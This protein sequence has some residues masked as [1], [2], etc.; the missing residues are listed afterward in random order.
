[1]TK[2]GFGAGVIT[3][4]VPVFLAGFSAR[5]EPATGVYDELEARAVVIDDDR[6]RLC[7]V[8]CDLLGMSPGVSRRVRTEVSEAIELPV[9]RVLTACTHT[10]TGPSLLQGT[11][12]LGWPTPPE[13]EATV[14]HGC[15]V[16]ARQAVAALEPGSLFCARRSLPEAVSMNRRQ[17]PYDPTFAVLDAR[18]D[19]GTTIGTLANVGIHPVALGPHCL[20]VSTDWVGPFRA[21]LSAATGGEAALLQ[22]ALGDVNPVEPHHHDEHG[23]YHHAA[24]IGR[25]V[26]EAVRAILAELEP[27]AGPVGAAVS[28]TIAAP[29]GR[30]PITAMTKLKGD[31]DVELV[32]WGLGD[33]RLVSIPGEAFHAFGNEVM[34]S[35]TGEVLL[36][37]LAPSW[38]GYLP[39]PWGDGYEEGVSYGEP[40]VDAVLANLIV[41]PLAG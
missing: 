30:T 7:L 32:E 13:Y 9:E 23:D 4:E 29:V 18:R 2:I 15:V 26:A 25:G 21:A 33:V 28:R 36:A 24:D 40:F 3:P 10:H 27:I 12:A 20:Q 35:R 39:R 1:M 19:D 14:R 37:G 41:D 11:E 22:G 6:G 38:Q 8:V 31:L 17:L 16:A 34:A 5:T